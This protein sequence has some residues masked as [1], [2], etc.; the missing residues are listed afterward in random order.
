MTKEEAFEMLCEV[1][2]GQ[3][4]E[5]LGC[6]DANT[7]ISEIFENDCNDNP[8]QLLELFII[9]CSEEDFLSLKD[10]INVD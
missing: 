9:N 6:A 3:L 7:A 8:L 4:P 5:Q 10:A 2:V 1:L